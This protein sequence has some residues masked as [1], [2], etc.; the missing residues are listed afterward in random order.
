[1]SELNIVDVIGRRICIEPLG[2]GSYRG[3]CPF[4]NKKTHSAHFILETP[5]MWIDKEEGT[6]ICFDCK[7]EGDAQ[8]FL[9]KFES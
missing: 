6:F 1:M 5:T 8:D 4:H 7:E 2:Y 3:V 9:N